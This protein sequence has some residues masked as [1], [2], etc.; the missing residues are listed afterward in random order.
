MPEQTSFMVKT[1][2]S[3]SSLH[4]RA[5]SELSHFKNIPTSFIAAILPFCSLTKSNACF[6]RDS[7]QE[8]STNFSMDSNLIG[9]ISTLF[10][11]TDLAPYFWLVI[12]VVTGSAGT[13]H[14]T[15]SPFEK[16]R[17][18]PLDWL[19]LPMLFIVWQ[20][21]TKFKQHVTWLSDRHTCIRTFGLSIV[22]EHWLKI[23]VTDFGVIVLVTGS[24]PTLTSD[25]FVALNA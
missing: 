2:A 18:D 7:V 24:F 5:I 1:D 15:C 23:R 21:H 8:N 19:T 3:R 14:H 20:G 4:S 25:E 9:S 13:N 6:I 11:F 12:S 16:D 10:R 22:L 17:I